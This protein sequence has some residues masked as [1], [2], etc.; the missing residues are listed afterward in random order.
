MFSVQHPDTKN[1]FFFLFFSFIFPSKSLVFL[2]LQ[3]PNVLGKKS[4]PTDRIS[5]SFCVAV[6]TFENFHRL[7]NKIYQ[8]LKHDKE[9]DAELLHTVSS[10]TGKTNYFKGSVYVVGALCM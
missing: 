2:D 10:T 7:Q 1:T 4:Q 3:P 6:I 9:N 8:V 5:P